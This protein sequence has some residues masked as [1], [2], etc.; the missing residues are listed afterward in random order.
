MNFNK[1]KGPPTFLGPEPFAASARDLWRDAEELAEGGFSGFSG[2][3]K[4]ELR[5]SRLLQLP[6]FRGFRGLGFRGV[7]VQG[8][9]V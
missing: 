9:G 7:R 6:G 1:R 2:S 4:A 3:G 8:L 5:A